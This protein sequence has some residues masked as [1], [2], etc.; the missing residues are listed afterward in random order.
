MVNCEAV[1]CSPK[2]DA[3]LVKATLKDFKSVS[4][5]IVSES[6]KRTKVLV[7]SVLFNLS[8]KH[9]APNG[10]LEKIEKIRKKL[11]EENYN[12]F[13]GDEKKIH[14][15]TKRKLSFLSSSTKKI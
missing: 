15:N 6:D 3:E 8:L 5:S 10:E 14:A 13:K 7:G 4:D 1:E 12:R 11:E 9:R 2:K